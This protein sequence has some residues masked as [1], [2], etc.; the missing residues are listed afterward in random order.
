MK[1]Y[2]MFILYFYLFNQIYFYVNYFY[3]FDVHKWK[4]KLLTI[5]KEIDKIERCKSRY[6][7]I[8]NEIFI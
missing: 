7:T 1:N 8:Q 2:H 3:L 6:L 4:K 5:T